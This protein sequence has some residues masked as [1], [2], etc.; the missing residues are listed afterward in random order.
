M[1]WWRCWAPKAG[2]S[3]H[4]V[5][6]LLSTKKRVLFRMGV[7]PVVVT[8]TGGFSH[9]VAAVLG[10]EP[11]YMACRDQIASLFPS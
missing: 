4:E 2:G 6:A 7:V 10:T 11:M 8:E 9:G 5:V 3:P 1:G